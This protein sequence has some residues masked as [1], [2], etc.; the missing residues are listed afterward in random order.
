MFLWPN[1]CPRVS[2]LARRLPTKPRMRLGICLAKPTRTVR[3]P[4]ELLCMVRYSNRIMYYTHLT[5]LPFLALFRMEQAACALRIAVLSHMHFG[6]GCLVIWV[7]QSRLRCPVA[8]SRS[9][10]F[11]S[12]SRTQTLD[13]ISARPASRL[14]SRPKQSPVDGVRLSGCQAT[15]L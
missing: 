11:R 3:D 2:R 8:R 14:S 13:S 4:D 5:L 1:T 6:M 7:W 12:T 10:L 9:W 15:A